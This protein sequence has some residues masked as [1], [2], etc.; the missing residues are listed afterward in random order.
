[1]T[2]MG[3]IVLV[4][5]GLTLSAGAGAADR[6]PFPT[7][8]ASWSGTRMMES[9]GMSV[10]SKVYQTPAKMRY[11]TEGTGGVVVIHRQD[12]GLQWMMISD[13]TYMET[14]LRDLDAGSPE[15]GV[16]PDGVRIVEQGELGSRTIEGWETRGY[17]VVTEDEAGTRVEVETWVTGEGIPLL[18]QVA[19]EQDGKPVSAT[20]RTTDIRIG[21][22]DDSLF[23]VPADATRLSGGAAGTAAVGGVMGGITEA[24]AE[25][26][27][28][29]AEEGARDAVRNESRNRAE[30]ALRKGFKKLFGN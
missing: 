23:E 26:A 21:P 24:M 29:G 16:L 11:E 7:L 10:S 2:R 17:R 13:S 30:D 12:L 22:Q 25:E 27:Q 3:F 8:E 4:V 14:P 1:M 5:S 20:I 19:S 15:D 9:S 6:Y 18:M 28:A